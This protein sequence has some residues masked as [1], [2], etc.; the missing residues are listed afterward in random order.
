MRMSECVFRDVILYLFFQ[1][2]SDDDM[3]HFWV[4]ILPLDRMLAYWQ[5]E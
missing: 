3:V 1:R 5:L 2:I 4:L